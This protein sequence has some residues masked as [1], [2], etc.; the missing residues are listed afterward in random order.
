MNLNPQQEKAVNYTNGYGFVSAVP[1]AGK[2]RVLTERT[3]KLLADGVSPENILCI[4]FT[5]KAAKE[6]KERITT[7]IGKDIASRLWVSTFH[8]MGAKILRKEIDEIPHYDKNFTI[9]D[10][11]DQK[12]ILE[13]G[14]DALGYKIKNKDNKNGVDLDYIRGQIN[15][16]K[17]KLT[18]DIQFS[19]EHDEPTSKMFQYYKD[20]LIKTNCMDFGDLLYIFYLL[21]S[22]K[23]SIAK[24][25][26]E[27][28]KY[29]MV[30]ECQDLN[31]CQYEI[32]KIL[33][34]QNGN[35]MLI[36]DFDQSIY[37][38]R[39]ADPK[40]ILKYM[41]ERSVDRL[42]LSFNYRSTKNILK[43]AEY[44]IKNNTTRMSDKLE[45]INEDGEFV[46]VVHFADY[47]N[48]DKW[49]TKEIKK[50]VNSGKFQYSDIAIL[51]RTNALSRP[52]EQSL[53]INSIPCKVI[54][55][56]SF[57]DLVVV[58]TCLNYLQFYDNP[59]NVLAFSKIIN[60][61]RRSI[62]IEMV[63]KIEKFCFENKCNVVFALENIDRLEITSIGKKRREELL[64]FYSVVKRKEEDGDSLLAIGNRIFND[65]GLVDYF[66]EIDA[67]GKDDAK[68]GR[69][70]SIEIYD[71]FMT[72]LKEWDE[73]NG[74][75][76]EK[77]LEY[78]NLQTSND[79]VDNSNSVKLMTMH[80]SKGLEFPVVFIISV[81]EGC[82]PHQYSLE[83]HN[84][85]DLEE[86][87]RLFYV[88]MTR[89]KKRLY[90][91]HTTK[92]VRYGSVETRFPSRF[93]NE[94]KKSGSVLVTVENSYLV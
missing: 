64:K 1:G 28:F 43:C 2:T 15:V 41:K 19:E 12:S 63:N 16:K 56:K 89:A 92:R 4:T 37:R 75:E 71:S 52:F 88:G 51:Y 34:E 80:T 17:D 77:F 73:T 8:S 67:K 48:E 87:R 45:T 65:S 35:L 32:V 69:S 54:G 11:D 18:S 46:D 74:G 47:Y 20:Y 68:N 85:E 55:G 60:K 86:E 29:I 33:A 70:S 42:P 53:R 72:M 50:L 81:E 58:K 24:R 21:L 5:N 61:P 38:F 36:G 93:I 79:L 90:V 91:T 3:V 31:H 40:N 7:S 49:I 66:K 23:K 94:I 84:P 57:F 76:L 78:I 10:D 44:L 39:Q 83:T 59:N 14:A 82:V 26:G 30:D 13:K 27:R 22:N 9:I 6:M 25:Y 62:A